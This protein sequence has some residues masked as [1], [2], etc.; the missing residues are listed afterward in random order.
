MKNWYWQAVLML[1]A[2]AI[3]DGC[4]PHTP[5]VQVHSVA[6][7]AAR[8]PPPPM[9]APAAPPV[10]P[11]PSVV[12]DRTLR[13]LVNSA[14]R[15]LELLRGHTVLASYPV[16][17]GFHGSAPDRVRGD[18]VTPLG[19]YHVASIRWA[20]PYGPF[21]LL[22]YPNRRDA[23]WGL[24]QGIITRSQYRRILRA[25]D[26]GGTPPQNTPLGG[27]IGIHGMGPQF[28]DRPGS[29]VFPGRWT[30]GCVALSNWDAEQLAA[31]VRAGT[32]V[33]I[34]GNVPGYAPRIRKNRGGAGPA[35]RPVVVRDG[36]KL[37]T[38][39][40]SLKEPIAAEPSP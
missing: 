13:I 2:G 26:S 35:L 16:A 4:A 12:A 21:M 17:I 28:P 20:T 10:S 23:A 24:R 14:N 40:A 18:N 3:L 32:P 11:A 31:M 8:I 34:V 29:K 5:A 1:A 36:R 7:Y 30:A 15:R 39:L 33:E 38:L 19:K 22:S 6:Y 37:D 9:C 25:V 27:Y